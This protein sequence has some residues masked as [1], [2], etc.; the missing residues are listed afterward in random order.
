[1]SIYSCNSD[2][3]NDLADDSPDSRTDIAIVPEWSKEAIWYQIFPERF[4]NGDP[5]NDPTIIDIKGTFPEQIP[6]NWRTTEWGH[7]WYKPDEW[8]SQS[9]LNNKWDN[10]Q[11]RRYG[12]DLQGVIDKL[13]YLQD[14]G[15]NAIY[16]NPLNDAP[17]LHKYDPRTWVHI[18]VNF[19][20]DPDQDKRIIAD[21]SQNDPNTWKFTT[22]DRLFLELIK[23]CKKRKI[24]IIMDYSWN[25]TGKEFWAFKEVKEQG[26][27]SMFA[28]WYDINKFDDPNTAANEFDYTGW[29]GVKFM[30]EIRK[31]IL[32]DQTEIPR[33]GNIY[34]ETAKNHIFNVARRWLDPNKDG[35]TSD[36][37]DGYRLDVA[38]LLPVDFLR[39]FRIEVRKI[40]PEAYIIGEIWWKKWPEELLTPNA[41]LQG[42]MFDAIMNYRWYNC[43]R[44]FFA[45]APEAL[46]PS[47]FVK[48]LEEKLNGIDFNRSQAMMNLISSHDSPRAS[49]SIYN[50]GKYKY[51]VKPYDNPSYKIDK[52]DAYTRKIQKMLLIHQF[53][54]VGAPH[55]WYGDEVGMWGAD[56]PDTRKPMVWDDIKYEDEKTHPFNQTRK[57][58]KVQQDKELFKFYKA[59]IKIRKENPALSHGDLHFILADDEN[60]LLAYSRVYKEI[61]IIAVFNKSKEEKNVVLKT[62][63]GG[64]YTNLFD[65]HQT[66]LSNKHKMTIQINGEEAVILK[67]TKP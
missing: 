6:T 19:G 9:N 65:E 29:S 45:D 18:D 37:I 53:T 52:P 56:D 61:E 35:D 43:A 64:N 54:Y 1:M 3:T 30:P 63:F 11:L 28:D 50:P 2:E 5:K 16:F 48:L 67:Y 33:Q 47:E 66:Y 17:S 26:E 38:E 59:L 15:I 36:G 40:N 20:P 57:I 49:T 41:F 24:R 14:L 62:E 21:E 58:D 31:E 22:A 46:K 23:E 55:I 32:G 34:S 42:D 60:K 8:F 12:G 13:D 4:R 27:K 7:D 51:Q 10:L 39:E 44:Q 25:H